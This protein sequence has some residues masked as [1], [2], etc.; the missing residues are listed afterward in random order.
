MTS[1]LYFLINKT[2]TQLHTSSTFVIVGGGKKQCNLFQ[3]TNS[4]AMWHRCY[5]KSKWRLVDHVFLQ[6]KGRAGRCGPNLWPED[7]HLPRTCGWVYINKANK[8]HNRALL[9]IP[10]LPTNGKFDQITQKQLQPLPTRGGSRKVAVTMFKNDIIFYQIRD[11]QI[12]NRNTC[13]KWYKQ[14]KFMQDSYSK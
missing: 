2:Y 9:L 14:L 7:A 13:K 5:R 12:G 8:M 6:Q 4:C 3:N 1:S 10:V 11:Q